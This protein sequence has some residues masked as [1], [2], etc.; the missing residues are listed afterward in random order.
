MSS[1]AGLS[2]NYTSIGQLNFTWKAFAS[3][4]FT[5]GNA[6][7][8]KNKTAEIVTVLRVTFFLIFFKSC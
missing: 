4:D 3:W 2:R 1:N 7:A 8:A 5:I 6:E